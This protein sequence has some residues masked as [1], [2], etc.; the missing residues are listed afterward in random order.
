[1]VIKR[2]SLAELAPA[3]YNPRKM[4]DAAYKG[5][6]RSIERFGLVQPI[7]FNKQTGRVISGHQR[8]RVL[9]DAGV[10]KEQV[11]V[12]DL[13]EA[14]E[15]ALNLA[16]NNPAIAGEFTDDVRA[17]LE[18]L[19]ELLPDAC[20]DLRLGDI[21]DLN[22]ADFKTDFQAEDLDGLAPLDE[23]SGDEVS[24]PECGHKWRISAK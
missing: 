5:L 6:K 16:M 12:V 10:D 24:C 1:M 20:V 14:E 21:A 11:V 3:E 15:K 22:L 19:Q 2:M 4:T 18:E 7:V 9:L 13:P 17:I 8:L 23:F